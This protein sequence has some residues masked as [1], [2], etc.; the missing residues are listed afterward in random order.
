LFAGVGDARH[1]FT[2]LY[3]I[4]E[5]EQETKVDAEIS[6]PDRRKI[7]SSRFHF[8][9]LDLKFPVLARDLVMFLVI[10]QL[11]LTDLDTSESQDLAAA[12][13]FLYLAPLLPRYV[14]NLLQA[15]VALAIKMLNNEEPLPIW[16]SIYERDTQGIIQALSIWQTEMSNRWTTAQVRQRTLN[17]TRTLKEKRA[18]DPY[19]YEEIHPRGCVQER[20]YYEAVGALWPPSSLLE[21]YEPDLQEIIKEYE[22]TDKNEEANLGKAKELVDRHWMPNI[23]LFDTDITEP[24]DQIDDIPIGHDPFHFE[25]KS[26]RAFS[27]YDNYSVRYRHFAPSRLCDHG[28]RLFHA[29]ARA[30]QHTRERT[31]VELM[32]GELTQTMDQFRLG[33]SPHRLSGKASGIE[34]DSFPMRYDRI[35]LSNIP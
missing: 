18:Q 2:T 24:G 35:H 14:F 30:L 21:K 15:K 22:S 20:A 10:D 8:S 26:S 25:W 33:V 11:S 13:F 4:F 9:A 6:E 1:V 17:C 31:V 7:F 32:A 19:A 27:W 16:L 34:V 23:L 29:V 5:K 12:A 3:S 28:G